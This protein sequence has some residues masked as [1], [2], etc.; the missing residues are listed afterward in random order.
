MLF[1]INHNNRNIGFFFN[2]FYN[3]LIFAI[4]FISNDYIDKYLHKIHDFHKQKRLKL[5]VHFFL[6]LLISILVLYLFWLIFGWGGC[7]LP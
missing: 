4:I 7:L 1:K 2:S 5:L 6:I 3:A